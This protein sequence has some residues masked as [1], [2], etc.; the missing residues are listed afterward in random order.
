MAQIE[1]HFVIRTFGFGELAQMYLPNITKES[2]SKTFSKWIILNSSLQ[3][4][5]SETNWKKGN[6]TFTPKQ[7]RLIIEHFDL[8]QIFV[9]NM[10]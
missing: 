4:K 1:N 10:E 5:L 8:P 6:K 2:A 3:T 7:V 9:A